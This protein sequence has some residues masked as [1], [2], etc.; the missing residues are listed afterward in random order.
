[1]IDKLCNIFFT[2]IAALH[3]TK[4]KKLGCNFNCVRKAV[5]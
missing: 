5:C 2:C 4:K 3:S 1:M